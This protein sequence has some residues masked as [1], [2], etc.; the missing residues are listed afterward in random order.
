MHTAAFTIQGM[1]C[2]G[3]AQ[4][5]RKLVAGQPGVRTAQVSFTE[6]RARILYDP[7]AVTRTRLAQVIEGAGYTVTGGAD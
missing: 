3:C 4:N 6:G 5:I 1:H 2:D 7:K